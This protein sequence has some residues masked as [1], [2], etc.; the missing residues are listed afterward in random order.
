[1]KLYRLATLLILL[2]SS[3]VLPRVALAEAS[4]APLVDDQVVF[5]GTYTLPSGSVLNGNLL[6]FG[7]VVTL[8]EGSLVEGDVLAFGGSV[9]MDGEVAGNMVAMGA[10]VSLG[11]GA[12]IRGDVIAPGTAVHR[13]AGA[14]ILGDLITESGPFSFSVPDVP[15]IQIDPIPFERTP[16]RFSINFSPA[17]DVLWFLFRTF[18]ISALAVLVVMFLPEH[19]RRTAEAVV[20]EPVVS[21]GL[22][23]LTAMVVPIMLALL[24]LFTLFLLSPVSL[25]GG[26]VL[27]VAIA[28][29]WIVIGYEVGRRLAEGF[30]QQWNPALEA[31][32]GT[33]VLTFVSGMIAFVPCI[34]WL[35]PVT[36]GAIGLGGTLLTRFGSREYLSGSTAVVEAEVVEPPPEPKPRAKRK[37]AP[38]AKKKE[39]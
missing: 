38:K 29:G 4:E 22:G 21:G 11:E 14:Q 3:F 20:R 25:L 19:S 1:M 31:G 7:G 35:A 8:E 2:I 18:A 26:I 30:K 13:E 9:D 17:T 36:V 32:V 24:T 34:G 6:V 37:T 5:G 12:V 16:S 33:F 10:V 23:L 27:V 15:E 39:E 28:F